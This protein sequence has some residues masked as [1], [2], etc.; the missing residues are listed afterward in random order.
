MLGDFRFFVDH[1]RVKFKYKCLSYFL[2]IGLKLSQ[3]SLKPVTVFNCFI[4]ATQELQIHVH[5]QKPH[6]ATVAFIK[7]RGENMEIFRV[8]GRYVTISF[9]PVQYVSILYV[10]V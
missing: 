1:L 7:L 3:I 8:H 10:S 9:F 5:V 4:K 2:Q 6:E